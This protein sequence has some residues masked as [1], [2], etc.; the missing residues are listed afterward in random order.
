MAAQLIVPAVQNQPPAV[1]QGVFFGP[2]I[3]NNLLH[4][5]DARRFD[6][7]V[8]DGPLANNE[9]RL[10]LLRDICTEQ[11][12]MYDTASTMAQIVPIFQQAVP[13]A[14]TFHQ[15]FTKRPNYQ[16]S[17]W[18]FMKQ[19]VQY[20]KL[21]HVR[22]PPA[23]PGLRRERFEIT[24]M[25]QASQ[26]RFE[27][28]PQQQMMLQML[29]S[30]QQQA[31]AAAHNAGTLT[32]AFVQF[33]QEQRD[34]QRESLGKKATELFMQSVALVRA[35]RPLPKEILEM[36]DAS[37][38]QVTDPKFL[39]NFGANASMFVLPIVLTRNDTMEGA[40][41]QIAAHVQAHTPPTAALLAKAQ[42]PE[43][44]VK[45]G[46]Y[47]LKNSELFQRIGSLCDR[48]YEDNKHNAKPRKFSR[49]LFYTSILDLAQLHLL[50]DNKAQYTHGF[51]AIPDLPTHLKHPTFGSAFDQVNLIWLF[52]T[53]YKSKIDRMAKA[54]TTEF[55]RVWKAMPTPPSGKNKKRKKR[56]KNTDSAAGP[57]ASEAGGTS[58]EE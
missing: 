34:V 9:A 19:F 57:S 16:A 12:L 58:D 42:R 50:S 4:L 20:G 1:Q 53:M 15:L 36:C 31:A 8:L 3:S 26:E 25:P 49:A 48:L 45:L 23:T 29:H 39:R 55:K 2:Q 22:G 46:E 32:T 38:K 52:D 18:I 13:N 35:A 30:S 47:M 54:L 27:T 51:T 7:M 41:E 6:E 43:N 14:K 5:N 24:F 21:N 37:N 10:A 33:Q 44:E 11:G 56:K 28:H 40:R 17:G